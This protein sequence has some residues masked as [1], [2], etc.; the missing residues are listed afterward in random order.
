MPILT[1]ATLFTAI[2]LEVV[3]TTFLQRSE[4]FT[5]LMPT[6][7]MGLCYAGSFYFLSLA[8]RAMPLGI[9]YAIWSGLG[10]VLVSLIGLFLFGQRLDLAA[11]IGLT[12]IV[13]G[14]IIVNMFS[15]SVTH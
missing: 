8:L 11:V 1:Y 2:A 7:L 4:Q 10:I 9:A 3:G 5:R 13:G 12:M 15:T 14:V 6:L